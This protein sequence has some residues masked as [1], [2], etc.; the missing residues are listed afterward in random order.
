VVKTDETRKFLAFSYFFLGFNHFSLG[1]H[2]CSTVPNIEIHL[3]FGFIRFGLVDSDYVP[4]GIVYDKENPPRILIYFS[5]KAYMPFS[6]AIWVGEDID[7][8]FDD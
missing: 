3:P 1:I 4:A 8:E 6:T 5:W 7:R 2:F